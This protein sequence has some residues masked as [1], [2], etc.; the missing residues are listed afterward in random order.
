[1]KS[2]TYLRVPRLTTQSAKI[3]LYPRLILTEQFSFYDRNIFIL[4]YSKDI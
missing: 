1:M 3:I 2:P 4:K